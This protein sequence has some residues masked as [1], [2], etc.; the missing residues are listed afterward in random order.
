[1]EKDILIEKHSFR[2]HIIFV[3]KCYFLIAKRSIQNSFA[4]I[5]KFSKE[6]NFSNFPVISTSETELWNPNDNRENWILTAGKV[7]NLRIAAKK[8]NGIEIKAHEI[9]SFWK[10]IGNPNWGKNFVV[11]REIREG[12]IIPTIAGGLCQISNALYDAALKAN[13]KIIERHQHTKIIKGSL[14]EQNRDATVKWNYKDLRFQSETDFK[15]EVKLTSDQLIIVFKSARKEGKTPSIDY[16]KKESHKLNDCYSCGNFSCHLNPKENKKQEKIETT[17]FILDENW[18]EYDDYISNITSEE[19]VFI[20]PL[21]KNKLLQTKRYFWNASH[22]KKA[23]YLSFQSVYRA[24]F[25][26]FLKNR[27]NVFELSL[28]LDKK[29]ANAAIKKI[30]I[31]STHIIVSQNL[32]PFLYENGAFGGRTYDVLMNRLPL[33]KLHERLDFAHN[34]W[35]ES[36]TLNDF[37]TSEKL[38]LLEYKALTKARKIISPHSEIAEIFNHKTEKLSWSYDILKNSEGHKILFPAS[39]LARK[40]ALEMKIIAKEL[41][42]KLSIL[43]NE[44]ETKNF[45]ENI[46][47]EKFNGNFNEIGMVI[48]P[49][50]IENQPRQLLK[51]ISYG[52][53][54]ITTKAS[55]LQESEQVKFVEFGDI[56]GFIK[57]FNNFQIEQNVH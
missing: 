47:V 29:L 31:H 54:I 25:F 4:R 52:I 48:F 26:R 7:E 27:R 35:K 53:P 13:F 19:D 23:Y 17:T 11:G 43:G 41:N 37:R 22:G 12:C 6:E 21:R 1:M 20:L 2:E 8:L 18:K 36:K 28:S 9:F 57:K 46:A 49:T 10:H 39:S 56:S 45:W 16:L 40:G 42:L 50:Y 30:P 55:G 44:T 33:E 32:L 5:R 34:F 15:I 51:A 24:L 3:S 14:A 38:I